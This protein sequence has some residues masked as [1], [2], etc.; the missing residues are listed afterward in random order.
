MLNEVTAKEEIVIRDIDISLVDG[1]RNNFDI[2]KD[3]REDLYSS[4]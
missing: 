2:K 3:R 4:L 1:I